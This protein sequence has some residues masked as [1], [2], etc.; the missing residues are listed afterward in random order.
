NVSDY[1]YRWSAQDLTTLDKIPYIG[2]ITKTQSNVFVATGFR[3]L[4]MTNGTIAAKVITEYILNRKNPYMEL[5]TPSRYQINPSLKQFT[6]VNFDVAKHLI[7][8]K[9]ENTKDIQSIENLTPGNALV[10]RINGNRTGVFMD[11]NH[12]V[13]ML[14]TTCTHLRCEVEWNSGD[15]TWDCPCHGSRFSYTGEVI[16]GPATRPLDQ[17]II[18]D[19]KKEK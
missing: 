4:G 5:F 9:L 6:A 15:Q 8:G 11:E 12:K 19:F 7:K 1:M 2:S 3:K 16:T 18:D 17:T 10:T 13:Y 14:D